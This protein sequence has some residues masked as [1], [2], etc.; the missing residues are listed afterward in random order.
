[1]YHTLSYDGHTYR[2]MADRQTDRLKD[3]QTDSK[4]A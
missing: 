1:M 2:Q 3:R 4:P